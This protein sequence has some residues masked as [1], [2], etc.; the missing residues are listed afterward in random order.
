[1]HNNSIIGH[2]VNSSVNKLTKWCRS[3]SW[4][5][6]LRFYGLRP[7]EKPAFRP[8]CEPLESSPYTFY[9]FKIRFNII[10]SSTLDLP[11]AVYPLTFSV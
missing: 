4:S 1:M 9:I 8:Y 5:R 6:N 7:S 2:C 11:S 3:F 10:L